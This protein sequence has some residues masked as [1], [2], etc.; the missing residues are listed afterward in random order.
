MPCIKAIIA[1]HFKMFFRDMLD[2]EFDEFNDG[3]FFLDIGIIFMPVIVENNIFAV[4]GIDTF[5]GNDRPAEIPADVFYN[6][7]GIA[8]IGL[9]IDIKAVFILVVNTGFDFLEGRTDL[10]FHLVKE[11]SLKS[12][13]EKTVM[14]MSDIA[15]ETIIRESAL[16]NEAVDVWIPFQRASEGVEDTDETGNK[17]F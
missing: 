8:E 9:C 12:L 7:I 17:V 6:G 16:G 3:K 14:E 5:E 4:I 11:S 15:P 10:F 1:C 13:P 2:Q